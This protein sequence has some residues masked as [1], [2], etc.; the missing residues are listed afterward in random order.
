MKLF[1]KNIGDTM[2]DIMEGRNA[3]CGLSIGVLSGAGKKNEL[4]TVANM[5]LNNISDLNK[6]LRQ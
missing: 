3:N 5:V 2:N 6:Y 4:N 1:L